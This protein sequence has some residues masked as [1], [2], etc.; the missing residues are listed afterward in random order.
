MV[1]KGEQGAH[2]QQDDDL[3]D[4]EEAGDDRPEHAGGLVWDRASPVKR[5]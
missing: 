1:I 2:T 5:G 3:E 4:D